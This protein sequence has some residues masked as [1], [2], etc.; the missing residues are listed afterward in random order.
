[1]R[2]TNS[3]QAVGERE[4]GVFIST[5][6]YQIL[7]TNRTE[8]LILLDEGQDFEA[9]CTE[10]CRMDDA[11]CEGSL[12]ESKWQDIATFLRKRNVTVIEPVGAQ[13]LADYY[14]E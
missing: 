13:V 4:P 8:Y 7:K 1:M 14:G 9:L 5:D 6:S 10:W 2:T 11:F 12:P 3:E